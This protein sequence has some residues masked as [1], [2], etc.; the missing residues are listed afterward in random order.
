MTQIPSSKYANQNDPKADGIEFNT[1]HELQTKSTKKVQNLIS[2]T[3]LD[4]SE[5]SK[6]SSES[7]LSLISDSED[8]ELKEDRSERTEVPKSV[9]LPIPKRIGSDDRTKVQTNQVNIDFKQQNKERL[10]HAAVCNV[11]S[12]EW[13]DLDSTLSLLNQSAIAEPKQGKILNSSTYTEGDSLKHTSESIIGF[14]FEPKFHRNQRKSVPD[15][16]SD[17]NTI[18]SNRNLAFVDADVHVD[19]DQSEHT[20]VIRTSLPQP[21]KA[22]STFELM[23]GRHSDVENPFNFRQ[24]PIQIHHSS[25]YLLL[26]F[27]IEMLILANILYYFQIQEILNQSA[28]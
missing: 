11:S 1:L 26:A 22:Q 23:R 16:I 9:L 15:S 20:R 13:E 5:N 24:T 3:Q 19:S 28:A 10:I 27:N 6:S 14:G 17:W 25:E 7:Y 21:A 2:P 18:L 8:V 12:M 4:A